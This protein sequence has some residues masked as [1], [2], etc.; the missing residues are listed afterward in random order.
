MYNRG[1]SIIKILSENLVN[2]IAAGEVIERPA[3]VVKE[4]VENSLDAGATKITV[5]IKDGGKSLIKISDNGCGMNREDLQM[6]LQR[7]ATS[8]I[9]EEKDL[10]NIKTMGFRGEA[11]ASISSVSQLSIRSKSKEDIAGSE[12]NCDGGEIINMKDYAMDDGTEVQV[13]SLF[14]NTPAREKYLKKE[15]TELSHITSLL[16]TVALANPAVAFKLI[17][18][19]K[20]IADYKKC[21]DLISRI[22]EVFGKATA[23]AMIPVFYGGSEFK[24][25][26][27][28]GKPAISRS[29]SQ[30]QYFFVNGRY[31]QHFV[32]ANSIKQAY[33]SMLMEN[34]KPVFI[35][36]IRIDPALIDVNVHPRKLEI[37][38]EDQQTII[39]RIYSSV[40]SALEK[41]SL[42]PKGFSESRRYMA[43]SFPEKEESA[44]SFDVPT[45]AAPSFGTR[46]FSGQD[47]DNRAPSFSRPSGSTQ[48]A[49][50]FTKNFMAERES[51]PIDSMKSVT[52]IANSY[53]VAENEEGLVLIDQHAA[54]ERVRYEQLMD[55]FKNEQKS[56]QPLIFPLQME[57]AHSE[58]QLIEENIEVF[59][60]LGF[61]IEPFGGKTFIVQSVPTFLAKENIDE[62]I[63]GVLD[64]IINEKTPNKFQG[65][66]DEIINYMACRSAIKFGKKLT[67]PEMQEL[68]SQLDKLKRPYTCPH[69]RP[70]MVSLTLSELEKMF[71]RK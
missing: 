37:R 34:K 54:H 2:Q 17:H 24:M 51:A 66:K 62:V 25:D 36:N 68:I 64:D 20:V 26:G 40:K 42:M 3:S 28:I 6:A 39:K 18:N 63:N 45:S 56:S 30:H 57:F 10:W 27:F 55:Q 53:I 21:S 58:Y 35:I 1:M 7:H 65:R 46:N 31:I 49:M 38:F 29:S 13:K 8:K 12:I 47:S 22:N 4:L 70:T 59:K 48:E 23:E 71:G 69:G 61:E 50:E 19:E 44:P 16:N 15:S 32:L 5:E 9:N 33:H 60:N 43:D 41:S 67:Q 52:Q 14:F 11:L